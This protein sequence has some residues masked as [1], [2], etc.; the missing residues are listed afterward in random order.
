[1]TDPA[2]E[3]TRD[4]RAPEIQLGIDLR[5]RAERLIAAAE[6]FAKAAEMLFRILV[7]IA[8]WG[9]L[10]VIVLLAA[11]AAL[12]VVVESSLS[13]GQD[14][15]NRIVDC[16]EPSGQCFQNGQKQTADAVSGIDMFAAWSAACAVE[17]SIEHLPLE[18]RGG[19]VAKCAAAHLP[20]A[21]H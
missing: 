17:P 11:I 2:D 19:A 8:I 21:G 10:A 20:K 4:E 16:V 12:F 18:Q 13:N 6:A 14:T 7:R 5:A 15:R 1:V 9:G 3:A